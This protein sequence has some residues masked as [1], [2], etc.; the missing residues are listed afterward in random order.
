MT[1]EKKPEETVE[2]RPDPKSGDEE[3][4]N[5]FDLARDLLTG[6]KKPA[7]IVETLLE[8]TFG[9]GPKKTEEAPKEATPS[10]DARL[11]AVR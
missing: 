2:D 10:P 3:I 11:R 6:E 5:L 8:K 1:D 9:R 4:N 7:S